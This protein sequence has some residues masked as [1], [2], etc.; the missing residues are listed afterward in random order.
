MKINLN[1]GLGYVSVLLNCRNRQILLNNVLLDTGSAGSIFSADRLLEI[2]LKIEPYDKVRQ[3]RGVGGTEFVF[4]KTIDRLSVGKL[5]TDNF[6]IEVGSMD[7]GIELDG[8]LGLD[9]M[10]QAGVII[11]LKKM[12]IY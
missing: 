3:I 10:L 4:M 5:E 9:F 11:N 7:Y 1:Q 2:G 8:I 12:E 6:E